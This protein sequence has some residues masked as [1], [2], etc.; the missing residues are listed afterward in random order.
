MVLFE[1]WSQPSLSRRHTAWSKQGLGAL[2]VVGVSY[3][4]VQSSLTFA[5]R[6]GAVF[7]DLSG[8]FVIKRVCL[9]L[10]RYVRREVGDWKVRNGHELDARIWG[11]TMSI[12]NMYV[13]WPRF[14]PSG[15]TRVD[16]H[17]FRSVWRTHMTHCVASRQ[18]IPTMSWSE[19]SFT[20]LLPV[21]VLVFPMAI[22]PCMVMTGLNG[23]QRA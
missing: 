19:R 22:L 14:V 2:Q 13:S 21:A 3:T 11:A 12:F 9:Y 5:L 15:F 6:L 8:F 20:V 18:S 7:Y 16:A 1:G 23:P 10:L 17:Y 4:A